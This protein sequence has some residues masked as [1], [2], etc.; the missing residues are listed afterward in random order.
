MVE[1]WSDGMMGRVSF[2]WILDSAIH[3]R[4]TAIEGGVILCYGS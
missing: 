2:F 1:Y 4:H 3:N